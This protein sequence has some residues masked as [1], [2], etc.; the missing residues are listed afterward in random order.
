MPYIKA[1]PR[2]IYCVRGLC[3]SPYPNHLKGCPNYGKRDSCPPKAAAMKDILDLSKSVFLIYNVFD[4]GSHIQRMKRKH[5]NWTQ[6]QLVCCLYWQGTARKQLRQEV[7]RFSALHP[8][9]KVLMI[10]EAHGLNVTET[11][12]SVGIWLE[13]PPLEKAYQVALAGIP[14][15]KEFDLFSREETPCS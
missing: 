15:K 3:A 2:M 5:P 9:F 13:W 4:I 12:K 8:E 6:R 11:M 14:W 1:N 7:S 10:P